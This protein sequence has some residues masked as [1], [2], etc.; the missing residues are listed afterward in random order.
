MVHVAPNPYRKYITV[1]RKGRAILFIKMQK[2]LYGLLRSALHFYRKLVAKL[3][4]DG[5]KLNPYDLCLTN[6][7]IDGKQMMVC[8]HV[9]NL[10]VLH[11]D[12]HQV[13][14]FGDWLSKKY[15]MAVATQ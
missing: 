1:D 4:G 11:L 13:T 10:K 8:W 12:P 6:K 7:D 3:E 15:A 5:F 9:D 14:I 2:A